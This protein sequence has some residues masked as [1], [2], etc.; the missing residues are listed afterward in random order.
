[1][2]FISGWY[3]MTLVMK[4]SSRL[5]S[6]EQATSKTDTSWDSFLTTTTYGVLADNGERHVDHYKDGTWMH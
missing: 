6:N 4:A 5:E 2:A 3:L 1:M